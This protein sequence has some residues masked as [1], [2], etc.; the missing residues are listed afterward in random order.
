[1]KKM[2]EEGQLTAEE[3]NKI[4]G[5]DKLMAER[6]KGMHEYQEQQARLREE[7]EQEPK[8]ETLVGNIDQRVIGGCVQYLNS[9]AWEKESFPDYWRR[10]TGEKEP[11]RGWEQLLAAQK[12]EMSKALEQESSKPDLKYA[13]EAPNARVIYG[14]YMRDG[15]K[16]PFDKWC[17]DRNIEVPNGW[18]H[19]EQEYKQQQQ[20]EMENEDDGM[21]M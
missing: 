19:V 10:Q 18:G 16:T 14:A 17:Q 3:Y 12:A 21:E 1:M 5:I 8:Q 11:P 4:T 2:L 13:A 20:S 15:A 9:G 7:Q 6:D